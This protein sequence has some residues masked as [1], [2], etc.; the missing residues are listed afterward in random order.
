VSATNGHTLSKEGTG[1]GGGVTPLPLSGEPAPL[2]ITDGRANAPTAQHGP[3]SRPAGWTKVEDLRAQCQIAEGL[4]ALQANSALTEA[5]SE[6]EH[7]K[8]RK[9]AQQVR[10]AELKEELRT[11]RDRLRDQRRARSEKLWTDRA[12]RARERLLN[13][14]RRLAATYRRYVVLSSVTIALIVFGTIRGAYTSHH[15]LAGPDGSW[16]FY[17]FEPAV[18][19][20]LVVSIFAQFTAVEHGKPNPR[21]FI[22]FDA[23]LAFAS[24]LL[25]T[26]PWANRFGWAWDSF[27][28]NSMSAL[29]IAAAVVVHHILKALFG[30]IFQDVHEE[31]DETLRLDPKSADIVILTERTR[32]AIRDGRIDLN[33]EGLPVKEQIRKLFVIAN[34]RA[35]QVQDAFRLLQTHADADLTSSIVER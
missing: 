13:P 30:G 5:L 32:Q 35:Q 16:V 2:A 29:L 15:G 12:K 21:S 31:L 1:I 14:N 28:A 33:E 34:G 3:P 27:I 24:L 18:S 9:V 17:L 25:T 19:V 8:R 20:L 6:D 4:V 26:V 7:R 11:A 23:V 10:A 22:A